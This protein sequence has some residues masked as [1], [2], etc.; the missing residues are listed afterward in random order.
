[1]QI[2]FCKL[3]QRPFSFSECR[4]MFYI[5]V[6]TLLMRVHKEMEI[7][8]INTILQERSTVK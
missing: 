2:N 4:E 3:L 6:L 8:F 1:M 5:Y 7:K